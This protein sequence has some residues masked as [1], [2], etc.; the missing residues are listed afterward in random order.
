MDKEKLVS[1]VVEKEIASKEEAEAEYKNKLKEAEKQFEFLTPEEQEKRAQKNF[2]T[3][4]EVMA[5][6]GL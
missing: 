2:V 3:F 4:F 6:S 1:M 5:K